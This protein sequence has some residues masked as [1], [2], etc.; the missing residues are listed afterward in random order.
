MRENKNKKITK[1]EHL[2]VTILFI[3]LSIESVKMLKKKKKRKQV[4]SYIIIK[5]IIFFFFSK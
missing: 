4:I 3:N 5:E 2:N 1:R